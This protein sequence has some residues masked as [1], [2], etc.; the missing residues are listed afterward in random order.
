M[1]RLANRKND[2]E[3][4]PPF[5]RWGWFK[6]EDLFDIK[7]GKRLTKEAMITG[8]TPFVG[9]SESGNGVTGYIDHKPIHK[10]NTISVTY[11]GSV[12]EAFYQPRDF[13]ASDDVNVLYPKFR[14]EP[15]TALFITALIKKEKYRFNYGRKWHVERMMQ[16]KI[17][18]P[19]NNKG[20]VDFDAIREYMESLYDIVGVLTNLKKSELDRKVE[21]KY[22]VWNSFELS[23]IFTFERGKCGS[24]EK[25]LEKGN[26]ISYIG[27]K[28]EDNGFM[29][30]VLRDEKYVTKGN[31]IVFI[32]DGQGSVGY[33]T[34]QGEDFIGSTTLSMGRNKSLNKY[35][36]LFVVPLLDKERF[37]YS[38]GRKWNGE[39]LKN[40]K[41]LLP[42]DTTG[43][44]DWQF[45]EEYIKSLPYSSSL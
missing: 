43:N 32:G 20:E 41:V 45:M 18:L 40:T 6:L 10:G 13:W 3:A 9:S 25:L 44:P 16:S 2:A 11:N 5:Y 24:A 37:K 1:R 26:E 39:K 31:C 19:I 34:Y 28:K 29:Y 38:F 15:Y 35:N 4:A 17:K 8:S 21:L 22:V 36:A 14:L 27:A 12:A 30:K 23:K 33:S 42:T 7:K